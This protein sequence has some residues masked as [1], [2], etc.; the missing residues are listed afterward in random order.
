MFQFI[1]TEKQLMKERR[2]REALRARQGQSEAASAILFVTLAE[3]GT[4]DEATAAEHTEL[5]APLSA[6][7][8]YKIGAIRQYG[9]ML[10]RCIQSHTLKEDW[11]PDKLPSLWKQ[12]GNPNEEFP[13]WSQPIGAQD[14]YEAGDKVSHKEKKWMSV[15]DANVWEP[16]TYGWEEYDSKR[17]E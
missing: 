3:A 4:I 16:G 7:V 2:E 13:P 8:S 9:G 6:G 12:I 14:A 11:S 5:F 10:Y 17:T 15:A 1:S